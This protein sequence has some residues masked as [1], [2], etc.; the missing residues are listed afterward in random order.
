MLK[1]VHRWVEE[2]ADRTLMELQEKIQQAHKI[3]VSLTT[4]FRALKELGFRLKKN[5]TR[6]NK[7]GP[8]SNRP[9]RLSGKK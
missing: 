8:R 4:I 3:Q 6:R 2:R 5:S 9:V 7:I 1:D